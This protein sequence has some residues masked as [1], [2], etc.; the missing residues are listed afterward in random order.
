MRAFSSSIRIATRFRLPI[1]GD[2]V[3]LL[4][5]YRIEEMIPYGL[6]VR[7][8][9]HCNWNVI[10]NAFQEGY[11]VQGIHPELAP[12][13][14]ESKERYRFMGDHSVATAPFGASNLADANPEQQIAAIRN[15]PATFPGVA[16]VLPH[17]DHLLDADRNTDSVVSLPEGTTPRRLLQQAMR[18]V[19]AAKGLDVGGRTDSQLSDNQFWI[20]FPNF[21]M[22]IHAG[23]ATVIVALPDSEGDPNRCCWHVMNLQWF[24]REERA[25][26]RTGLV[27]V[28][29]GEHYQYFRALEHDL[30]RWSASSGACAKQPTT[31]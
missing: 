22:T 13:T 20:L 11:H 19:L 27:E 17:F 3:E 10:M 2:A 16:E 24:P 26:R 1:L 6:N 15:L 7:E 29:E 9:I 8:R 14:D 18:D 5:P 28:P 21:F 25:A 31:T 23:E 4:A 30:C 12:A